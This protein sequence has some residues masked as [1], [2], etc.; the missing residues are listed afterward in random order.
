MT[1]ELE[2]EVNGR[3]Y[4]MN[5]R[6]FGKLLH[7]ARVHGWRP[8]RVEHEWPSDTWKTEIILPHIGAYMPGRVS[9]VDALGLKKALTRALATGSVAAEGTVQFASSTLMHMARGGA[10]W[11][12]LHNSESLDPQPLFEAVRS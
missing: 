6:A 9:R 12:R 1:L 10:F 7:L 11:V 4:L 3:K 8:E 5:P 2:S